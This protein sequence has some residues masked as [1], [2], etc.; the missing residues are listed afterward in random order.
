MCSLFALIPF[1]LLAV[2]GAA[3][4]S[5][6]AAPLAANAAPTMAALQPTLTPQ[7][8]A[9][10]A[11]AM[12][13]DSQMAAAQPTP[14]ALAL[15]MALI[16]PVPIACEP[17]PEA[18]SRALVDGFG[19]GALSADA[20]WAYT[21]SASLDKTVGTWVNDASGSVAYME[22]IHYDCGVPSSAVADYFNPQTYPIFFGNYSSY[23]LAA[24]CE[25]DGVKHFIFETAFN[26]ADYESRWWFETLAPT[27]LGMFLLT[28]P[29][30]QGSQAR[31]LAKQ[32]FPTLPDCL[33]VAG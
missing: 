17:I 32:L 33:T 23:A 9:F 27:R 5:T 30:S 25:N 12:P 15:E 29:V 1:V 31:A 8:F 26:G 2:F 20:G 18:V 6:P 11:P 7:V 3:F 19:N 28:T 4:G 24:S 14:A 16:T 13:D 22:L 21:P 10:E